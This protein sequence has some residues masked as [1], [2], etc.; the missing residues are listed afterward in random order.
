MIN[1]LPRLTA[2][3]ASETVVGD[4]SHDLLVRGVP[5]G[6]GLAL[7]SA[8]FA[9]SPDKASM[10][11]ATLAPSPMV[12]TY[13][14]GVVL[15]PSPI[16]LTL[17]ARVLSS[18]ALTSS[19]V[20]LRMITSPL[21]CSTASGFGVCLA[22]DPLLITVTGTAP[23]G[24]TVLHSLVAR[25]ELLSTRQLLLALRAIALGDDGVHL[26]YQRNSSSVGWSSAGDG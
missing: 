25:K 15:P 22:S 13:S 10:V 11:D 1:V 16:R 4:A 14:L 6:A 2:H 26:S 7:P 3:P 19:C 12:A 9:E 24:E 23:R 18:P 21:T 5:L 17:L 20:A 8:L